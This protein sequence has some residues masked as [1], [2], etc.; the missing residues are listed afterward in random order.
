MR[1][2]ESL[3]SACKEHCASFSEYESQDGKKYYHNAKT[4]TSV[5]DKPQCLTDLPGEFFGAVEFY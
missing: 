1:Q 4:N 5:W 2:V 3:L